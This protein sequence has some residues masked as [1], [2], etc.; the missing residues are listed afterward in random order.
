MRELKKVRRFRSEEIEGK[1]EEK[2]NG[3]ERR[4]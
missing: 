4:R 1:R 2:G 3:R